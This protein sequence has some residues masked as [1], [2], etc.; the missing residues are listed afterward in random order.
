MAIDLSERQDGV[1]Y[2]PHS[3]R[4]VEPMLNGLSGATST[5][6]ELFF[7]RSVPLLAWLLARF[8][9]VESERKHDDVDDTDYLVDG[10]EMAMQARCP[11]CLGEQWMMTVAAFSRGEH[12]CTKCGWYTTPMTYPQ[13]YEALRAK[14]DE[15]PL[16]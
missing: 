3:G 16:P 5:R 15:Q 13:W 11:H 10:Q 1:V 2:P 6:P 9:P 8:Q 4:P 14:R 12:G 7:G